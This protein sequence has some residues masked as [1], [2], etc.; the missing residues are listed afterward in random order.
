MLYDAYA[1]IINWR[2]YNVTGA[3]NVGRRTPQKQ[4]KIVVVDGDNIAAVKK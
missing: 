3:A 2:N 4:P 1:C